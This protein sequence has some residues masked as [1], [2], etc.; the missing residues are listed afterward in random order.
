MKLFR[1]FRLILLAFVLIVVVVAVAVGFLANRAV[2]AAVE[3]AGTKAL[4]VGV[5]VDDVDLSVR[6]GKIGLENLTIDNPPGYQHDKLLE[7]NRIDVLLDA[8]SLLED[9]V[10]ITHI[11]L[12]SGNVVIEQ[13]GV[14][15]NNLQ[16]IIEKLPEED[17]EPTGKK[18]HIDTLEVTNAEVKVKLL[19][20]PGKLDTLSFKLAPIKLTDLGGENGFDSVALT[21]TVLLAIA[22]KIAEQGA[23]VLPDEMLGSLVSELSKLEALPAALIKMLGVGVDFGT[24][25]GKG[26]GEGVLKGAEDIGK[27]ISE[28]LKAILGQKKKED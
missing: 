2:K 26:I 27:G 25:A 18:L 1:L 7:L 3:S 24:G 19:P 13:R 12:D 28:G 20:I 17:P 21:R 8:K 23:G 10:N 5:H 15:G 6:K 11:T 9:V 16:D 14:S 4:N 22:G